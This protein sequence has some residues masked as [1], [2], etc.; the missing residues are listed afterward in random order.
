MTVDYQELYDSLLPCP[1]CGGKEHRSVDVGYEAHAIECRDCGATGP[2]GKGRRAEAFPAWNRRVRDPIVAKA[3]LV[4]SL[5]NSEA[6]SQL[7]L[8]QA[9]EDSLGET[10]SQLDLAMAW[11]KRLIERMES[12]NYWY[13]TRFERLWHWAHNEVK[14]LSEKVAKRYFDIVA[15]GGTMDEPPTYAQQMNTLR[16]ERDSARRDLQKAEKELAA[17]RD[18]LANSTHRTVADLDY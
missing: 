8:A 3:E 14:P 2:M 11:G 18:A 9:L 6:A 12:S 13:A 7:E 1:F 16:W 4:A 15:N 17:A 5:A 10:Q